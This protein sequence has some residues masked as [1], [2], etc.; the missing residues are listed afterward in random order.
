MDQIKIDHQLKALYPTIQPGDTG[1]INGVRYTYK[2]SDIIMDQI[3]QLKRT[4]PDL[5]DVA[6]CAA[7]LKDPLNFTQPRFVLDP[8]VTAALR[9]DTNAAFTGAMGIAMGAAIARGDMD[10]A[11]A[12][13]AIGGLTKSAALGAAA[14]ASLEGGIP[15]AIAGG[16]LGNA[17]QGPLGPVLGGALGGAL[18]SELGKLAS[19]FMPPGLDAPIEAVKNAVKGI[20]SQLPFKTS[21]AA[22]VVNKAIQVKA[23]MNLGLKGPAAL[24]F[25]AIKS[26]LLSDIPGLGELAKEVNLQSQVANLASLA[27]NPVAFAAEAAGIKAQFPMINVNA[28]AA[29]MIAGA[30]VGALGGKGFNIKSMVPNMALTAAGIALKAL[31]GISPFKDAPKPVFTKRPPAPK[32]PIEIKNLFAEAGA[33]SAMMNLTKPLSQFMGIMATV[34]PPINTIAD[35]AAKTSLGTQKLIGNANTVN[36]GSGGYGRNTELD[37]KEKKRLE[38]TS[39][40]EQHTKELENMVDYSVLTSMSYPELIKKYPTIK[41]NMTVGEALYEI[42][43]AKAA[44]NTAISTA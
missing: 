18:G 23:L 3:D 26:N 20:T 5:I 40:I 28:L 24:I 11:F 22:D 30:A 33:A 39:K 31:P 43:K 16:V 19:D 4:N 9:G 8:G 35:S 10:G 34:A 29:N 6:V 25:T 27:S 32:A 17:L 1:A 42:E 44:A 38:L 41:P 2:G 15:G 14:G 7:M 37:N 12:S 21:G 13:G 36:W